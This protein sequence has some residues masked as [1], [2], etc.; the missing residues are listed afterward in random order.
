MPEPASHKLE[1]VQETILA[2]MLFEVDI[3]INA[4]SRNG[5]MV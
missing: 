3:S 5:T 1:V 2:N 4:R